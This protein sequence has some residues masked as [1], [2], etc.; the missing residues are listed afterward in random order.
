MGAKQYA[1]E[2]STRKK[3]KRP[4]RSSRSS[5]GSATGGH[6]RGSRCAGY[7]SFGLVVHA[8]TFFGAGPAAN[9]PGEVRG[10]GATGLDPLTAR[11][12]ALAVASELPV[13]VLL[14]DQAGA[15]VR[16]VRLPKAPPAGGPGNCWTRRSTPSSTTCRR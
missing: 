12:H 4:M 9:D 13:N 16:A 5:A 15:L 6:Y 14:T 2:P 7:A 1:T 8:D 11:E 10:L 3:K